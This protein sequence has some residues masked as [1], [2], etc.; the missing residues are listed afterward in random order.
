MRLLVENI[1]E[2]KT[3]L[4]KDTVIIFNDIGNNISQAASKLL[5]YAEQAGSKVICIGNESNF[6]DP[7]KIRFLKDIK[8]TCG[9][10][11]ETRYKGFL[12]QK[13][14]YNKKNQ[15]NFIPENK[16]KNTISSGDKLILPHEDKDRLLKIMLEVKEFYAN[17]LFSEQGE[18]AREYMH[19]RGF[20]DEQLKKFGFGLSFNNGI[21]NFAKSKGYSKDDLVALSLMTQKD[22]GQS[23][24]FYRNRIMIPIND[25]EG[26]CLGFGGRIYRQYEI[27]KKISKYINPR[28]TVLFDK[29]ST[30]FGMDNA[31]ESIREKGAIIVEGYMDAIAMQKSGIKNVVAVL[32]TSLTNENIS[33]LSNLTDDIILLFDND[34]AGKL[35]ARRSYLQSLKF[36]L[37]M[38]FATV[39]N[40]K[41]PDEFLKEHGTDKFYSS[42]IDKK[43]PLDLF[44]NR[45]YL[46]SMDEKNS[47][48]QT[49]F[50]WRKEI[51]PEILGIEDLMK[52]SFE[53][54]SAS[55]AFQVP[56][57]QLLE[58]KHYKFIPIAFLNEEEKQERDNYYKSKNQN[59]TITKPFD[60]TNKSKEK[61]KETLREVELRNGVIFEMKAKNIEEI[62]PV[63]INL[64]K[65]SNQKFI[66]NL[67]WD[68]CF[69]ETLLLEEIKNENNP[70]LLEIYKYKE[71]NYKDLSPQK[72]SLVLTENIHNNEIK[73]SEN[74]KVFNEFHNYKKIISS[75]E[76]GEISSKQAQHFD[77][78]K[79]HYYVHSFMVEQVKSISE[80]SFESTAEKT[81]YFEGLISPDKLD[82]YLQNIR[83]LEVEK[84]HDTIRNEIFIDFKSSL[85]NHENKAE[86]QEAFNK[87]SEPHKNEIYKTSFD[88]VL[89]NQIDKNQSIA[90]NY[91]KIGSYFEDI[92]VNKTTRNQL[93]NKFLDAL[94]KNTVQFNEKSLQEKVKNHDQIKD[95]VLDNNHLREK[96]RRFE[97]ELKGIVKNKLKNNEN[98]N[99]VFNEIRKTLVNESKYINRNEKDKY[100]SYFNLADNKNTPIFKDII[101]D[102]KINAIEKMVQNSNIDASKPIETKI[103]QRLEPNFL[104]DYSEIYQQKSPMEDIEFEIKKLTNKIGLNHDYS[105]KV[106][107][108]K[109]ANLGSNI[110]S[111]SDNDINHLKSIFDDNIYSNETN[112]HN[113]NSLELKK[114]KFRRNTLSL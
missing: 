7:E 13:Q 34:K 80:K 93:I 25:E 112:K 5:K 1:E 111:S 35:A 16:L 49:I 55:L 2:K 23:Y 30:L 50:S 97:Y 71:N 113:N 79:L 32:G 105:S 91:T 59:T 62:T 110:S 14:Y 70:Y 22:D 89:P 87:I 78:G 68:I 101:E 95:S 41:D 90:D 36:P 106:N 12:K 77:N 56:L 18:I 51:L 4:D 10:N 76:N 42:V 46:E 8:R 73:L 47:K 19:K 43:I 96:V 11:L 21:E 3:K 48:L 20:T 65:S 53:L 17:N 40:G 61:L 54:Q 39:K 31:K 67:K 58:K 92:K 33:N 94:K 114:N 9:V 72:L 52:R 66:D 63:N 75:I 82:Q 102:L 28:K 86:F 29:S 15:Q 38:S 100:K 69:N 74:D 108:I 37:N 83:F 84:F 60:N 45:T 98:L 107:P 85:Q 64:F 109:N 26:N 103:A 6:N 57:T 88:E 27:D 104:N 81:S 99:L 44:I 24:D